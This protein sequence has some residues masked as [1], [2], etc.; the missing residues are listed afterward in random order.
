[1]NITDVVRVNFPR[2]NSINSL[3]NL[4]VDGGAKVTFDAVTSY[5][6]PAATLTINWRARNSGTVLSFPELE[7]I[8]GTI[9][10]DG[11]L[12]IS[13]E[14]GSRIL[15]PKLQVITKA[16]DGSSLNTSRV[17]LKSSSTGSMLYAPSLYIFSDNDVAP[18]SEISQGI[19]SSIVLGRLSQQGVRGVTLIGV[20]LP[21]TSP[22]PRLEL[23]RL[24]GAWQISLPALAGRSYQLR[25]SSTLAPGSWNPVGAAVGGNNDWL[26]FSVP[27]TDTKAFFRVDVSP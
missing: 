1:L 26:R 6:G 9:A 12:Y 23:K 22:I 18:K 21:P 15:L 13:A 11:Y 16:S 19:G 20:A 5:S 4:F 2:L 24:E 7:T 25:K 14:S 8:T 27:Q 10:N 17:E 3:R